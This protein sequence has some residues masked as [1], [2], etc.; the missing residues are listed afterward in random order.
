MKNLLQRL[1]I[2]IGLIVAAPVTASVDKGGKLPF[3][4][5]VS[6]IFTGDEISAG[7]VPLVVNT[8]LNSP[9]PPTNSGITASLFFTVQ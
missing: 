4:L 6:F 2:S 7:E 5:L 1:L 9:V 3:C 8:Y